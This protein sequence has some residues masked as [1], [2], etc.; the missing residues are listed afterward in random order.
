[1]KAYLA[2]TSVWGWAAGDRRPDIAVRLA[3]RFEA[4]DV[5]TCSPVVL[6]TM[7]LAG[8]GSEYEHVYRSLFEP[9]RW[10]PLRDSDA[11]RAVV[12]QRELAQGTHGNHRP[13]ASDYLIAAIAEAAGPDVV[14]WFFDKD[15]RVICEHTGQPYEAEE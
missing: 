2:D 9:L 15:L 8:T 13:P 12:V 14:L 6:E 1:M 3:E 4:G 7:H 10:L 11:N 5:V